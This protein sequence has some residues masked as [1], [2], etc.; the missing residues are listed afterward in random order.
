MSVGRGVGGEGEEGESNYR[1]YPTIASLKKKK[2]VNRHCGASFC[3]FLVFS[4]FVCQET[5]H[6]LSDLSP[7]AL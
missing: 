5:R 4:F 2:K 3:L 6:G 1:W 7:P